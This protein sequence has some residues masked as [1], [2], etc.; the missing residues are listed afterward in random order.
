MAGQDTLLYI[1]TI[2]SPY[3]QKKYFYLFSMNDTEHNFV[4][5]Y[6]DY[7]YNKK[8]SSMKYEKHVSYVHYLRNDN[9]I[10]QKIRNAFASNWYMST[11]LFS[12]PS[13]NIQNFVMNYWVF[14]DIDFK[15]VIDVSDVVKTKKF[16]KE[17]L[18]KVM[19][20]IDMAVFS[21]GGIHLYKKLED[22]VY[23]KQEWLEKESD[24]VSKIEG[25]TSLKCDEKV[26]NNFINIL[27]VPGTINL[28]YKDGNKHRFV[29]LL[30]LKK[31]LYTSFLSRKI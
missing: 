29:D 15:Q 5:F 3:P 1:H 21:G 30:Y 26:S 19:E 11:A 27:R 17:V 4:Y 25:L 12:R 9:E 24:F 2:V 6:S 20:E 10:I 18:E 7:R 23:N 13:Y 22:P 14:V 16:A 8:Y 28:R 31:S